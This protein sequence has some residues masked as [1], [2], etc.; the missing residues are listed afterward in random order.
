MHYILL[1]IGKR[2]QRD[3]QTHNKV[4]NELK[5]PWQKSDQKKKNNSISKLK[6]EEHTNST[7]TCG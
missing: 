7:K 1:K 4:E 3:I 2:Y 5:M 6:T